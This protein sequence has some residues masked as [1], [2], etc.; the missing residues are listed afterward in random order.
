MS[1]IQRDA[2]VPPRDIALNQ[3]R[4]SRHRTARRRETWLAYALM[5][6]T[7]VLMG[8]VL[9]YPVGWEVWVSLTSFSVRAPAREFVGLANYRAMLGDPLFWR[10]IAITVAYFLVTTG[11]KLALGLGMALLLARPARLRA[12]VFLAVFLPWAYPGGVTVVAWY[13]MLNPPLITSYSLVAGNLKHAVDAVLGPGAWAFVSVAL[14]NVW[15]GG[16]FT[17]VFLLAGLNAIPTEL[18][19]YA[20]LETRNGWQRLRHVTVPLLRPFLALAVFLS[21]T[22]A[23]ADLANVWMLTGGRIVF[24]V[25]GTYAYWLGIRNGQF[26]EAAAWSLSLVPL[27]ALALLV[28]FRWFDPPAERPA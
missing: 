10:A 19:D 26:A 16:S 7:V 15:R 22:G 9:A 27:L 4:V 11:A 3:E 5:A 13:W 23:F 21:F 8:V 24:P 20:A 14:F 1:T 6:P 18:F 2:A 25:I 28:L 17:A 12:L